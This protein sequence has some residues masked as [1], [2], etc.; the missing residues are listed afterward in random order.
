MNWCHKVVVF[1]PGCLL[2]PALQAGSSEKNSS[3]PEAFRTV[4]E[5]YPVGLMQMPCP[6]A[7]FPDGLNGLGRLPHGIQYY[8]M[9]EGFRTHCTRL[10]QQTADHILS[11]QRTGYTVAVAG[12][13]HSPT[14]AVSYM[15]TRQGTVRRAGLFLDRLM[16]TLAATS[17]DVSYIG[18]NRSFPRKAVKALEDAILAAGGDDLCIEKGVCDSRRYQYG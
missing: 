6:E 2:C 16:N 12:I 17:T 11:F 15:Y 10:A 4:W 14:C 13:E 9:L 1:V 3:W 18:I 5:K 8:E 7:T